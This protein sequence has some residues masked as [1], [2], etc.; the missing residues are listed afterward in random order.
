MSLAGISDSD[1]LAWSPHAA[2]P[3]RCESVNRSPFVSV[4]T[5]VHN[6]EAYLR[7]CIESVLAQT[8]SH[9]DYTIVNNSSTDRTLAIAQEY[10]V[11]D[12]RIRIWNSDTFVRVE[13]S[14]N[15]AFRQISPASEYCKVVGADDTLFPECLAKMVEV[16]EAHPTVA[17]V[18]AYGLMGTKVE[19]Q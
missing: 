1:A 3:Y 2:Q 14:Y 10:A 11:V 5:P 17:I 18:G 8:Y 6:G 19:W 12:P 15:N 9:W 13:Q 7:E 4:V 16:A